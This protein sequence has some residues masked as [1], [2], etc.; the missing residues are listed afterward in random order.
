MST[1]APSTR[2]NKRPPSLEQGD[3]FAPKLHGQCAR[4][5]KK[6]KKSIGPSS[7]RTNRFL[8][9]AVPSESLSASS[10]TATPSDNVYPPSSSKASAQVSKN[11]KASHFPPLRI[12]PIEVSDD[13][14]DFER[15]VSHPTPKKR[16][17]KREDSPQEPTRF[18]ASLR[19]ALPKEAGYRSDSVDEWDEKSN[20]ARREVQ[21]YGEHTP[22]ARSF[23]PAPQNADP[24]TATKLERGRPNSIANVVKD[25]IR[26]SPVRRFLDFLE[27]LLEAESNLP[28][29]EILMTMSADL[30]S[31]SSD[32]FVVVDQTAVI[33]P[34]RLQQLT[35]LM[36]DC[37][38]ARRRA[39]RT[40]TQS[41]RQQAT[42]Q[43]EPSTLAEVDPDEL[44]K[45]LRALQTTLKIG[46]GV[47]PFPLAV[48]I[49]QH[50]RDEGIESR[51]PKDRRLKFQR[52]EAIMSGSMAD[53]H[54][55]E[56]NCDERDSGDEAKNSGLSDQ[57]EVEDEALR[58]GPGRQEPVKAK[59]KRKG[60]LTK[61]SR[62]ESG[63]KAS[64]PLPE[65]LPSVEQQQALAEQLSRIATT[66]MALECSFSLLSIE[67]VSHT[68]VSEDVLKPCFE[69]LRAVLDQLVYPYIEACASIGVGGS[70]PLLSAW[71]SAMA[72]EIKAKRGRQ[73]K[74]KMQAEL[75]APGQIDSDPLGI[76]QGCAE[77][78][79]SI[80]RHTCS[81]MSFAQQLVQTPTVALSES[82]V[83]SAVY[84]GMGP[85]FISEP[86]TATGASDAAKASA[87][88][89]RAL[90]S[91]APGAVTGSLA[92]KSLRQHAL[93]L[94]RNIFARHPDQ[95]QWIIEEIMLSLSKVPD[96][97]RNRNQYHLRNGTSINSITALLLQ[98]VQTS[99]CG[100][101]ER[102]L[103]KRA[104]SGENS[105]AAIQI[106][107]EAH[108]RRQEDEAIQADLPESEEAGAAHLE[109][110]HNF[111]SLGK[112]Y[113][114]G[115]LRRALEGPGQVAK[116]IAVFL[117]NKVTQTKVIKSSGDFSYAMVS[118]SL[119]A[120]LISTVFL[121]EWPAA[122]LLL[123]SMCWTF[124]AILD[125]PKSPLD[126]KGVALEQTGIIAAYFR[127]SQLK[128][129]SLRPSPE[130]QMSGMRPMPV[131]LAV[132]ESEE[133]S[134]ALEHLNSAYVM[135]LN[136]LVATDAD[137]QASLSAVDFVIS[138]WGAELS[139]SLIRTSAL[140][141]TVR[142][143]DNN[144]DQDRSRARRVELLLA[145][146]HQSLLLLTQH[147]ER[148]SY[149][150]GA[151]E[152]RG[153]TSSDS[154][155]AVTIVSEQLAHTTS[156]LVTFD[157]MRSMLI[158]SLHGQAVGIRTKALRSL[159]NIYD[160]DVNLL[161]PAPVREAVETRLSDES[162]GV[163]EA[164]VALLSKY[165]LREPDDIDA[166]YS[167]LAER[168]YDAGLA[169]RKR[170]LKLLASTYRTL[171]SRDMRIDACIR[172][173]RCVVDEDV[174][175]QDIAVQTLSNIWLGVRLDQGAKTDPEDGKT[176][177][178][179]S[180]ER[181]SATPT[182]TVATIEAVADEG[183]SHLDDDV[184]IIVSVTSAIRE[185]PSPIEEVFRRFGKQ[186]SEREMSG[187]VERLRT[188]SDV[189]IAALDESTSDDATCSP[190]SPA[191]ILTYIKTLYLVVS[192]N[193][194]VMSITKAKA[195]LQH[196]RGGRQGTDQAM[197]CEHILKIFR[198]SLPLMPKTALAFAKQ[199][200]AALRPW[201]NSPPTHAGALQEFIHCYAT[202]VKS[203]TE[204]YTSLIHTFGQ[205]LKALR[206]V[207]MRLQQQPSLPLDIKFS[208]V[209]SQTA[210][211]AEK[212]DFDTLKEEK[213]EL[214]KNIVSACG[215]G[216][217]STVKD[218]VFG[219]FL[220]IRRTGVS[221]AAA[222]LRDMGFL[223]RGFPLL[224]TQD[225]GTQVMD[226]VFASGTAAET[227]RLL[228]TIL[229]FLNTDAE[230][231]APERSATE[232]TAAASAVTLGRRRPKTNTSGGK[233]NMSE[234]VGN[235]DTFADS[236]V[237]SILV[238]RY[239]T[240]ILEAALDVKN[241]SV[242]HPALDILKFVVM[243]GLTH[244]LQCVPTLISLET[245]EDRAIAN[246]ALQMHE[247]LAMKHASILA[248]RYTELIKSTFEYQLG[249][250]RDNLQMMRGYRIDS[251]TGYPNALLHPWYSL[252]RDRRQTRLNFVKA[253][254]KLLDID[255]SSNQCSERTVL[256][257]RFVADNLATL[258]Y[259]TLEE[260]LVVVTD[261]KYIVS[262]T[263]AQVKHFAE[264]F[265]AAVECGNDD[266]MEWEAPSLRRD[267]DM[268]I[269]ISVK[270]GITDVATSET[271]RELEEARAAAG[272]EGED[273]MHPDDLC[274]DV[275]P[276][277][278][279]DTARMSVATGTALLLRSH[280]KQLY[281][282][283]ENRCA[284]FQP[285]KKQSSGADRPA[286]KKDVSNSALSFDTMPLAIDSMEPRGAAL[287]QLA[288][289][290][291]MMDSEC[292]LAEDP[293]DW[294][295]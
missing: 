276:R 144:Q 190:A 126:A 166:M 203:H 44:Q 9:P 228:R 224:M 247:H 277:T 40:M 254:V 273:K 29:K 234:L 153:V 189:L 152:G 292:A 287:E 104:E 180:E 7:V 253:M 272:A 217:A 142:K 27:D 261:I 202:V 282:L 41:T 280:L 139:S 255:T 34:T 45:L 220:D 182:N 242:Q 106:A 94:L 17:S 122:T 20:V 264:E 120:D 281:G 59:E 66:M 169:V 248:T 155:E 294:E 192:T 4:P 48:S 235:T 185:K 194:S 293:E 193:P 286:V 211:L 135:V 117:L 257:S 175:V 19:L 83:F 85:F 236:G 113:D 215:D 140:L 290:E 167:K 238:Q 136:H 103:N 225:E 154:Y 67:H 3:A 84:A 266:S 81:A 223:F 271:Q 243:Q 8:T 24:T 191:M 178:T 64:K 130:S 291:E 13:S 51:N 100:I 63:V 186:R 38:N 267:Q 98:L 121:P 129:E 28:D 207:R 284:K 110:S 55:E 221:Y 72:P 200:E 288:T 119:V 163:R 279:A 162:T 31:L 146:L 46:E 57:D 262:I 132:I 137:D 226:S 58:G 227:E 209:M 187:I 258:D 32:F 35:R 86:N 168:I 201:F 145:A 91:L 89:R 263:G 124:S 49:N 256:L 165:L 150:S 143:A 70:H 108:W 161:T 14:S 82:I 206:M 56:Q 131:S 36:R 53:E 107:M 270:H 47:N 214:V 73:N 157:F 68:L 12:K 118:E 251:A 133:E 158:K 171:P 196:L 15:E 116:S 111:D 54:D 102:V 127:A 37:S 69:I 138:E 93:S 23:A 10:D 2:A 260:V 230:R 208:L 90:S 283:S 172:M 176:T 148:I 5:K 61:S 173:V 1:L 115:S 95:R 123:S 195:L 231:R 105:G 237:S 170:T 197:T 109:A 241:P 11:T 285:G 159:N 71:V 18:I 52:S 204:D 213:P 76:F 151:S 141:D 164:A 245:L 87:R 268:N 295:E 244:P 177:A 275:P 79:A 212:A 114:L 39:T 184:S 252:L 65:A 75:K 181:R 88:G 188:I 199:L 125:D 160:V 210:L 232:A 77:Y 96:M 246:K 179:A 219:L 78:L 128:V 62:P 250:C 60:Q 50:G 239:L 289:F 99:A 25:A 240:P 147:V 174:G 183:N 249:L 26:A 74:G 33:K 21:Q 233:V 112:D 274:A 222:A 134:D 216:S 278:H 229:D 269:L 30:P 156:Y 205:L 16:H 218:T 265:V 259:K 198:V 97:K 22:S 42:E 6:P 43:S 92:M 149:R 101:G 80:F